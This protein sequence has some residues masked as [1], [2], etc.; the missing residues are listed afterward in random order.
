M[1]ERGFQIRADRILLLALGDPVAKHRD[2]VGR[3]NDADGACADR[4]RCHRCHAHRDC[5]QR[6]V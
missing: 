5:S 4:D 2:L 3:R 6:C 1:D